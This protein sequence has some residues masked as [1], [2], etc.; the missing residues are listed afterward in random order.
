MCQ[1]AMSYIKKRRSTLYRKT[2]N[3]SFNKTTQIPSLNKARRSIYSIL[4]Q[5]QVNIQVFT[6]KTVLQILGY[7]TIVL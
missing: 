3:Y 2:N 7:L 6:N 5:K 1:Q 4:V